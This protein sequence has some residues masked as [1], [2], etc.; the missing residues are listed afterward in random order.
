MFATLRGPDYKSPDFWGG[1]PRGGRGV[2][3]RHTEGCI[4]LPGEPRLA[5]H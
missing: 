2:G 1:R 3:A 4:N 5:D